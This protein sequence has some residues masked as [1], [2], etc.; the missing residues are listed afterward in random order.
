MAQ[1]VSNDA[2]W[3]KLSEMDKKLDTLSEVQKSSVPAQKPAENKP[4]FTVVKEDIITKI[5][6]EIGQLGRSSYSHFEANEKNIGAITE[7]I[8]KVWN[9][10]SRIR[11]QQR[12]TIEPPK[13]KDSHFKFLFFK[14]RKTSL[15][16]AI[17]G[18]LIFILTL[19][20]M[21]QQNDYSLLMGEYYRQGVEMKEMKAELDSLNVQI[22]TYTDKRRK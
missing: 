11:K 13:E 4:D 10:V 9:I 21:K 16:I 6:D 8:Q 5:K 12:E 22:K 17:L 14:V 2:L 19:F 7:T 20:G 18:V 1:S 15:V 3:V